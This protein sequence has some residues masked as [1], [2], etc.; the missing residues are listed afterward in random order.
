MSKTNNHILNGQFSEKSGIKFFIMFLDSMIEKNLH[1]LK[2]KT[3]KSSNFL[4]PSLLNYDTQDFIKIQNFPAERNCSSF[5][6]T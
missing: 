2:N 1:A 6:N 3:S 5:F 4:R